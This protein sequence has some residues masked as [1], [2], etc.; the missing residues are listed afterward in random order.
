MGQQRQRHQ[1]R[2]QRYLLALFAHRLPLPFPLFLLQTMMV[3]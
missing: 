2:R 3:K 1:Q